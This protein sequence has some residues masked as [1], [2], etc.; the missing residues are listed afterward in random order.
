MGRVVRGV[1]TLTPRYIL[2]QV[3]AVG[4]AR[5]QH[6]RAPA[7]HLRKFLFFKLPPRI[8]V[9]VRVRYDSLCRCSD[10]GYLGR[11]CSACGKAMQGAFVRALGTVYHLNCFKCMV[12]LLS[13]PDYRPHCRQPV[14]R[15]VA[16]S[17][18]PSSSR[19]MDPT[20]SSIHYARGTTSGVST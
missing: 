5:P 3:E 19:S 1:C 10:Y 11:P 4:P 20:A 7:L 2:Q 8:I 15:T 17:S 6:T 14:N 9:G 12:S 13:A 16:P 18:L